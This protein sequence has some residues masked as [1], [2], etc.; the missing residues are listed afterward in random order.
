MSASVNVGN[1]EA[2]TKFFISYGFAEGCAMCLSLAVGCGPAGGSGGYNEELRNRA[3]RAALSR[4]RVPK[5]LMKEAPQT[6]AAGARDMSTSDT[7][8]LIP[9]GYEF[10]PSSLC[11]GLTA[12]VSR[13]LRPVWFKPAVV[14]TE[15]PTIQPKNGNA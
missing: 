5:L 14:V 13:L 8:T 1:D 9:P 11:D 7:N 4:G 12:L 15:G 6:D 10:H 2:I 3:R